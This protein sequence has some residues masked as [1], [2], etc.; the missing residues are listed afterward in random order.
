MAPNKE[1][2]LNVV[3]ALHEDPDPENFT[4]AREVW[5][6]MRSR[7]GARPE[8]GT[9]GCAFGHYAARRDLQ[10]AFAI[11]RQGAFGASIREVT[12]GGEFGR[13]VYYCSDSVARHFG[14]SEGEI[15][16]LFGPDGCGGAKTSVDAADY[17]ENWVKEHCK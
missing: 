4:M 8:C 7:F 9:P 5:G 3:R 6:G 11:D 14:L 1:R 17:I 2:L 15:D 10:D 12:F 13:G 16:D